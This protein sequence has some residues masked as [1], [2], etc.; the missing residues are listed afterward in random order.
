[1]T[2]EK[3]FAFRCKFYYLRLNFYLLNSSIVSPTKIGNFFYSSYFG[4][5][6]VISVFLELY[7][8]WN[9]NNDAT[10]TL[11]RKIKL[12]WKNQPRVKISQ[13]LNIQK[14]RKFIIMQNPCSRKF[15]KTKQL[16]YL[17]YI[18][19]HQVLKSSIHFEAHKCHIL[20]R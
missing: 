9:I 10:F 17:E 7:F 15:Y 5:V 2:F 11:L 4:H 20:G 1:M 16:L 8:E 3:I 12:Q 18:Y 14:R 6:T 13:L 19:R